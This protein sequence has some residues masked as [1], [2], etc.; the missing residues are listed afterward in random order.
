MA[1]TVMVAT[2]G[3][4]PQVVTF[5]LDVLL[6]R[7]VG[8]DEVVVVHPGGERYRQ[9]LRRLAEAFPGDR[10][11]GRPC[12]LRSVLITAQQTVLADIRTT[13]DA[14]A[15]WRTLHELIGRLKETGA[16][17]HLVL[18]GGRRLMA[19]MAVSAAMLHLEHGDKVWHLYTPDG[20]QM[21][22]REGAVLHAGPGEGVELIEAP[23]L[24]WG[25]YIPALRSLLSASPAQVLAAQAGWLDGQEQGRCREVWEGLS[26]QQ[27]AVV[28]VFAAG[29][30]RQ[31]AAEALYLSVK[32]VD[33]HKT[34]VLALCR[35]VWGFPEAER[36]D[37]HFLARKFG[38]F[39]AQLEAV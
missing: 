1:R 12:H 7:G 17:L 13:A 3:G 39:L 37:Y 10:Y 26:E 14:D 11:Q 30:S 25:A 2:L 18:A 22:A 27:R 36:L 31:Q 20:L 32:T 19:L 15:V 6:A 8:V 29:H 5:A 23:L 21:R 34:A 16:R 28:R 24:P 38:P 33:T 9:S 4:Q 35:Q